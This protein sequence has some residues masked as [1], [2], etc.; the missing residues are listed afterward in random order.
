[1]LTAEGLLVNKRRPKH[2]FT[3][4]D[5]VRIIV[6]LWTKDDL[7]F[8]PERYR[9]QFTFITL[10]FCW[11]GA[12]IGAFFTDGLRY[13]D[14]ELVLQRTP[15][16]PWKCI[17]KID[18]RW[19]KNNRDPENIVFG[20]VLQEHDKFIFDDAS[21]LLVMAFLDK[22]LFGFD[23]L[24]DLQ[25]QQIPEGQDEIF[26]RWRESAL[27]KPI[28]RKCT[29]AGGL[30][31]EPMPGSAFSQIFQSTLLNAGYFC[32]ASVHSIRRQLGKKVDELYTEVQRSQHLTQADP[33]IFGQA[34]VANT[35]SVDGQGAFLGEPTTHKHIDYFQGLGRFREPGLPC[36]LPARLEEELKQDTKLQ[37]LETEA[38]QCPR[39]CPTALEQAKL[40]VTSHWKSLKRVALHEHQEKWVQERRDW[41][42]LT[43]GKKQADNPH[44]ADL[45]HSL[46]LLF[47]ERLRLAQKLASDGTL[48]SEDRWL[49]MEDLYTLV[50]P[51]SLCPL[52]SRSPTCKRVLPCE[53]LS[54]Q[55]RMVSRPACFTT[56]LTHLLIILVYPNANATNT[57]KLVFAARSPANAN[58]S[59]P[60]FIIAISAFTGWLGQRNGKNTV[61]HTLK[62]WT[63]RDAEQ[64]HT[65]TRSCVQGIVL[66]A[67][68]MLLRPLINA[69]N[70]GVVTPHYGNM[71]TVTS[72]M[73]GGR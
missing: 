58:G 31:D 12:R 59:R 26:L 1:M 2:N 32:A 73:Q 20:T 19:V 53:V 65:V 71:S 67:W 56:D 64:S 37:E 69:F 21:F 55:P 66:S 15:N 18:Q 28:L 25:E 39:D 72:M 57:S 49:A 47:P 46:S 34:Y 7:N 42:I 40:L 13:K 38:Q 6:C 50:H 44:R 52:P 8:I 51:R 16:A 24:R 9:I 27:D 60:T 63:P 70:R 35:S 29:K 10:V 17:Y 54:V 48:T 23:T 4:T 11:T 3:A 41:Q 61:N 62:S 36:E 68:E 22:A 43:R 30:T 5:L 45:T 14:I 33:R